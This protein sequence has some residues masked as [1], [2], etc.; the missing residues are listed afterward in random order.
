MDFNQILFSFINLLCLKFDNMSIL[1][2]LK[3][4]IAVSLDEHRQI[5]IKTPQSRADFIDFQFFIETL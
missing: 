5:V 3:A 1:N 2:T 4:L